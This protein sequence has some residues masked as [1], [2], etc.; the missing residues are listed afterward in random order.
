MT[1]SE[2]Y[3]E[4][5]NRDL[6]LRLNFNLLFEV[7]HS[8]FVYI[9]ITVNKQKKRWPSLERTTKVFCGTKLCRLTNRYIYYEDT[10]TFRNFRICLPVCN[11]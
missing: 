1:T 2:K 6:T 5:Y 9:T 7:P 3:Q 10:K 8:R 4:V 11:P